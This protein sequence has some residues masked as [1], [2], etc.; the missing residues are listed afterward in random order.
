MPKISI[1]VSSEMK[2]SMDDAEREVNWSAIAQRAFEAELNYVISI[3]EVKDM[4][5][6]I[7]RLRASKQ[8]SAADEIADAK[9]L[10]V[11][12][13]K[14]HAEYN[15][16]RRMSMVDT[17]GLDILSG[18]E[19]ATHIYGNVIEQ[20]DRPDKDELAELFLVDPDTIGFLT[21]EFVEGF[22]DGA[23]DVWEEI[24]GKI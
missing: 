8:K 11:E 4:S 5:E 23:K 19:A 17:D 7:E 20:D 14:L 12:W 15:E 6:V 1:Y 9:S 2:A 21:P 3:K 16:L 22:V 18:L 13:A 10:G 24:K